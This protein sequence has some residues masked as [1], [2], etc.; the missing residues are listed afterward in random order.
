MDDQKIRLW[1]IFYLA[2]LVAVLWATFLLIQGS[3]L[4]VSLTLVVIVIGFNVILLVIEAWSRRMGKNNPESPD[5]Q[6]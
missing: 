4:W 3:M 5:T 6:G 2:C 1:I